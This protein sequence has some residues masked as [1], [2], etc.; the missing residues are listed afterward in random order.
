MF[1]SAPPAPPPSLT[2]TDAAMLDALTAS[3]VE[4]RRAMASLEAI[5]EQILHA[6][7]ALALA[8]V[9]AARGDGDLPVREVAAELAAALRVSDRTIQRRLGEA[10]VLAEQFAAT[11]DA[12]AQGLISRAH[13]RVIVETGARIDDAALRA[14]YEQA[15]LA[16]AA[17]ETPGRLRSFARVAAE[18]V[19]PRGLDERHRDAAEG[20]CVRAADLDDGMSELSA[21]LP[22]TLAHGILDRLTQQARAVSAAA[23]DEERTLDQLRADLLCDVALTGMPVAHGPAEL[24]GA[25]TATV[26]VTVPVLT[27]GGA[28][29]VSGG[30]PGDGDPGGSGHPGGARDSGSPRGSGGFRNFDAPGVPRSRFEPAMLD[31]VQPVDVATALHLVGA[32]PGWDRVLTH[33]VTGAVLAVDRYRPSSDLRRYLRAIDE[34]CRFPGCMLPPRRCDVDHIDDAALGGATASDNLTTLCRRHHVLKHG[35]RWAYAKADDGT[36]TWTSPTGRSYPDR[37]MPRVAFTPAPSSVSDAE[38][39]PPF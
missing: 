36:I 19:L 11:H 23:T 10:S 2:A 30:A 18:R 38:P 32:A 20:R 29:E 25:I 8:H 5:E 4:T 17:R 14:R 6:A 34:R 27:L 15:A 3:I 22:T 26:S 21:L 12:L 16:V 37:V 13:A 28:S 31:G 7:N 1:D 33:P 39:P 9:D 24:L 35:T